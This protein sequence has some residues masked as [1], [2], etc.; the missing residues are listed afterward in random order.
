MAVFKSTRPP[1]VSLMFAKKVA[2]W[3]KFLLHK[4]GQIEIHQRPQEI[5]FYQIS[6][7]RTAFKSA[8]Q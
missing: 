6:I 5:F 1:A 4:R 8:H 3:P 2:K 7:S